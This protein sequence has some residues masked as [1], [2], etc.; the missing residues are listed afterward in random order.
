MNTYKIEVTD[1]FAGEANYCWVNRYTVK[2]KSIQGAVSKL[3][4]EIGAGWRVAYGD[5]MSARYNLKGACVCMFIEFDE[6]E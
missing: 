4:R 1:T 6:G 3:A 5:N 2:A